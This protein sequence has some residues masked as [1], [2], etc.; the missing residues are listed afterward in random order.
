MVIDMEKYL[1]PTND[2]LFKKIF[3]DKE[4]LKEFLNSV[5]DLPEMYKIKEIEFIPVEQLA[6]IHKGK[7]SVF[8]LKV[9]D[10]SG[11]C[12]IIEMQKRNEVD[13]LK[14]VQYYSAH[15]YV[16]QLKEGLTHF[17]LFPIIVISLIKT[18]IFDKEVPYIS[19]H[20]NVETSTNKPYL[21]DISY[22][23]IELGKFNKKE[24]TSIADEWLHLFKCAT[25]EE[26]PPANIKSSNV[27]EAYR[28]IELHRLTT[29]EYDLYIRTKLLEDAEEI[30][31][32]KNFADG[33]EEEKITIAKK[34]L[35]KGKSIDEISEF[36]ELSIEEIEKL[37]E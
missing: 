7:R 2:S 22:V 20:K 1:D 30:A 26:D 27:L 4:K 17:N 19:F 28:A 11:N 13:Y 5:L 16:Q 8:D 18:K 9:R 24:L 25:E 29:E 23:F 33:R 6:Q 35:A 14:R 32:A 31:L 3:R 36:T 21:C 34:M 15:S 12:Y 37:K 10:E